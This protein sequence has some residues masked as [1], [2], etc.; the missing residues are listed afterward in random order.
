MSPQTPAQKRAKQTLRQRKKRAYAL[1]NQLAQSQNITLDC[2]LSEYY[3]GN[4]EIEIIDKY[5]KFYGEFPD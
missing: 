2:F 5:E 3:K 4:F 1:V